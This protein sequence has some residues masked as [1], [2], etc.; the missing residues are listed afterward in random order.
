MPLLPTYSAQLGGATINGGRRATAEDL[1]GAAPYSPDLT[2]VAATAN[3]VANA[4][5]ED[6]QND[7]AR[8]ALIASTE[9]RAKY[10]QQLDQA[11]TNG[12]DLDKLKEAMQS[13]L[14]KVGENFQTKHGTEALQLYTANT[15]LMFDEQANAIEVRR[16]AYNAQLAGSKFLDTASG[17]IQSNPA[18][19]PFAEKDAEALASTFS[20]ISPEHRAVIVTGLKQE[21]NAA[22]A[23]SAARTDPEG[24]KKKLEAG[25]WFLTPE[26]RSTALNKAET[27]IRAKRAEEAYA[28]AE[29][30]RKRHELDDKARDTHFADIIA[31]KATRRS[32]MDDV[33]LLP[34]TREHLINVM[35]TR[36]KEGLNSEK[37]SDPVALRNL[38]M[39]IN[40]PDGDPNKVYN[41]DA[42]FEGVRSGRIN[43]TDANQLNNLVAAQKDENGRSIGT[44][45]GG[46][47]SVVGRALSQD[48]QF[49]AQPALVAE[50]QND[51]QARVYEKVNQLRKEKKDP[52]SVFDPTSSDY[53]GSREFIQSS[54]TAAKAR[55]RGVGAAAP[56]D[57]GELVERDG[58]VYEFMGGDPGNSKNWQ[59]RGKRP[60]AAPA[61]T[62][63]GKI[64]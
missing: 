10:A 64:Q 19:L 43:V 57:K 48:P 18:Y 44:K 54:I 27:E 46:L 8:T 63:G 29:Q 24:T 41:G 36:A 12:A 60:A 39:R 22:A 35:E 26:Q 37:R 17:I 32:I 62:S 34:A 30:E 5:I 40:A 20:R 52:N 25:D 31:G 15:G 13:D 38:W 28:R 56:V 7:E 23:I 2:G 61:R 33:T 6:K 51:Y 4:L 3:K 9:I 14:A 1:T 53:V 42:I 59:N 49:T 55:A 16:A 45:L 50:I 58:V 47:M 11:A 21:L